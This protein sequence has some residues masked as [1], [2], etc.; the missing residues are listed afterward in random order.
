[1]RELFANRIAEKA[2]MM[3]R[4]RAGSALTSIPR[5]DADPGVELPPVIEGDPTIVSEFSSVGV[6]TPSR[7]PRLRR[8]GVWL[9]GA[10]SIVVLSG[11]GLVFAFA[12]KPQRSAPLESVAA[13]TVPIAASS[14]EV[15]PAPPASISLEIAS[16]PSGAKVKIDGADKGT[17]PLSVE[18]Q[19]GS[20][21]VSID[22]EKSGY[23]SLRESVVPD[24]DQRITLTLT[25]NPTPVHAAP[26]GPK[27]HRVD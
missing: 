11:A 19:R 21:R 9:L 1:M 18:L 5:A 23:G 16:S 17:T 25:K 22:L 10:A 4:L 13:S 3:R 26:K 24:K 20:N 8:R 14:V 15:A 27:Y 12:R 6:V 7:L 2:E